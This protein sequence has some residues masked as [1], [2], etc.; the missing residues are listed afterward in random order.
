MIDRLMVAKDASLEGIHDS[1]RV[2]LCYFSLSP[3]SKDNCGD[4]DGR[5]LDGMGAGDG[6]KYGS[7]I[8]SGNGNATGYGD[9]DGHGGGNGFGGL[10]HAY[11]NGSNE[12]P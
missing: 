9:G 5:D 11:G 10:V 3:R 8:G 4:G 7:G 12:H 2:I 6:D 1:N